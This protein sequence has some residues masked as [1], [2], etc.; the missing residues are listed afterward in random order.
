MNRIKECRIKSGL[1]QRSVATELGVKQPTVYAYEAGKTK[2]SSEGLAKMA[3]LFGVTV[4]Y[5]TGKDEVEV[6]PVEVPKKVQNKPTTRKKIQKKVASA[7]KET[8]VSEMAMD[9]FARLTSDNKEKAL[10]YIQYLEFLQ[11]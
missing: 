9:I 8:K 11:K 2:Q 7:K 6:V 5:L 3:E 10:S 4:D 1:S